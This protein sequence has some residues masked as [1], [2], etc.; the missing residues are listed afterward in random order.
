MGLSNASKT[1]RNYSSL[2]TQNQGGGDKKAGLKP[3]VG[4]GYMRTTYY[5]QNY[6]TGKCCTLT[7][8]QLT[9]NPAVCISRGIGSNVQFNTYFSC[10]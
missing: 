7:A 9:A 5:K 2:I 4:K 8:L 3:S 10:P 6:K 1:A